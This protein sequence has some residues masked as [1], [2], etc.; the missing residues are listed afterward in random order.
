MKASVP[1]AR[2][3]WPT[4]SLDVRRGLGGKGRNGGA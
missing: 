3:G 1:G 2:A 4:P